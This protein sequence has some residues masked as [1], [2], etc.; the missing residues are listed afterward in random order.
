MRKTA[1]DLE[2]ENARPP[3]A[4]VVAP[5]AGSDDGVGLPDP[6]MVRLARELGEENQGSVGLWGYTFEARSAGAVDAFKRLGL[7]AFFD[8]G[9]IRVN[10][11][12]AQAPAV[13]RTALDLG[14]EPIG[15]VPR[16]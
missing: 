15:N 14:L 4:V 8:R 16:G 10:F 7:H 6:R 2:R 11:A 12:P 1:Q 3:E 13:A 9:A 5:G